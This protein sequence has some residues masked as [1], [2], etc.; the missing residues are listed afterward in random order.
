MWTLSQTASKLLKAKKKIYHVR[1]C[2]YISSVIRII[3]K[4]RN[5]IE[6]FVKKAFIGLTLACEI[7][8]YIKYGSQYL[9]FKH[10][11]YFQKLYNNY[12]TW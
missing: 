8:V 1:H 11:T 2:L 10:I 7:E 12:N 5:A 3:K 4:Y 6:K 9:D